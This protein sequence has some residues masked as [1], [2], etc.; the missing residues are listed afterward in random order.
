MVR[1]V[2]LALLVLCSCTEQTFIAPPASDRQQ[3][4]TTGAI[5]FSYPAAWSRTQW[6]QPSSFT[7][8]VAAVSNQPLKKPC[9][10][11]ANGWSC[12][13]PVDSLQ[14]GS[15][16]IEWW[17]NGFPNW[18]LADQP[19]KETTVGGLPAK[20]QDPGDVP[21]VCGGIGADSALRVEI[22]RSAQANY[23]EFDACFRGPGSDAERSFALAMLDGARFSS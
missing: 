4:V 20:I 8:M 21:R 3:T 13:Q 2:V 16:L 17:T 7:F 1:A 19:G 9:T 6:D 22:A 14:S 5:T 18:T 10:E 12:G 11:L 23:F 15:V